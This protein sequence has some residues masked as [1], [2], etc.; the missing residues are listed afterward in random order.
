MRP[1]VKKPSPV[2]VS[3][4]LIVDSIVLTK[5]VL[6]S[7]RNNLPMPLDNIILQQVEATQEMPIWER[8]E[9]N[10]RILFLT[11]LLAI[12]TVVLVSL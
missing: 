10:L 2:D 9:P 8:P 7:I 5:D 3:R 12:A 6:H 11:A 4:E 1:A